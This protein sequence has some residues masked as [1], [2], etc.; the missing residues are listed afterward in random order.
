M[1]RKI[2]FFILIH[3]F[4]ISTTY[5]DSLSYLEFQHIST[6]KG[7]S[8]TT[9]QSIFQDSNG[10]IWIGTQEGLNRYDGQS[11]VQFNNIQDDVKSLS[12]NVIRDIVEDE[13]KIL[14]IATNNGLNRFDSSSNSFSRVPLI[15]GG[16]NNTF[17]LNTLFTDNN[18]VL[19]GTDGHGL[20]SVNTDKSSDSAE[21]V[22]WLEPLKDADVRSIFK[23]SRGRYW[24]GTDGKG[25]WVLDDRGQIISNFLFDENDVSSISHNRIRAIMED[26]KGQ[27]WIGTRGGGLNKFSELDKTFIRYEHD[28]LDLTSL[29]SN[30]VYKILEDSE[31][32]LWIG[33]DGGINI[34][35]PESNDFLRM[36]NRS[37]Q[38]SGLSHNRVLTMIEDKGGLIWL[39][40]LAGLNI[41]NPVTAKFWHYRNISEEKNSLSDNTIHG[42]EESS[43]GDIFV[44]TFGGGLNR[45]DI[46]TKIWSVVDRD[47]KGN[48]L[49]LDKRLTTLMF[50]YKKN[51][52]IGS[53]SSGVTILSP[54]LHSVWRF[55]H[56]VTAPD[57][58]SA[59]GITDIL[60]DSD[61]TTWVATYSGGLNRLNKDGKTFRHY[62]LDDESTNGL[63]SENIFQVIEDDEGYIWLATDGGGVSRLD[64]HTEKIVN[65]VHQK[66]IKNSLSSNAI[67]SIY[68]DSHGRFWIGTQGRGLNRWEPE[69]RRQGKNKFIHY[70]IN[71]GLPGS[72]V[73]GVLE[74]DGGYI[75]ISTN[76]GVSRLDPAT[77]EIKN[78]D[79]ALG[80]HKNEL[81]QGAMLK[82]KDGRLY[83]GGLNG[84]SA[85]YPNEITNNTNIP[86]V[87][88]TDISSENKYLNFDA[89]LTNLKRVNFTHKDY[90]LTFEFAALD[91]AQPDRNQYQYK[92]EGFDPD[93]IQNNNL[94]RATYTN[95][96]SGNYIFKVKGSNNDG[97]WSDE[98]INLHVI[99]E[100]APWVSW[101]AFVIYTIL[102]CVLLILI[103]RSQAK[104]IANQ[105]MFQQQVA[106]KVSSKT[107]IFKK[108]NISLK[109]QVKNHQH[110]SGKDLA[111]GLPNQSFFT[112]QLLISLGWL[113][114]LSNQKNNEQKLCCV[115]VKL[116]GDKDNIEN[117]LIALSQKIA[118]TEENIHL[119]ARWNTNELAMLSFV[120]S[121]KQ[122][123]EQIKK[124][125]IHAESES[126]KNN[127]SIGYTLSP[128]HQ[129]DEQCFKW[130]NILMLTEHAMRSANKQDKNGYIGL[131]ACYQKLSPTLIKNIMTN[132]NILNLDDI[133][134]IDSEL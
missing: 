56:D 33:T 57:S 88:L 62:R 74:D 36:Q 2:I 119:I 32:K 38:P 70:T 26:S 108:D 86:P 60:Q 118:D 73:N 84:I 20:Y 93:W 31:R 29:S 35:R 13:K 5:S 47:K 95:L 22:Q 98:S 48:S 94:N 99:I 51:L 14:W 19:I 112:E 122:A 113:K 39:G 126:N 133:F 12:S 30:R 69:D 116:T 102:F 97:V 96:P 50:D 92:L 104:R 82:A 123:T 63:I 114:N 72:T 37:S 42:L 8:Q 77:N 76:K 132:E 117:Q 52:W 66:E 9:A 54:D 1:C 87:V 58:L 106:D 10:Y 80:I 107:E 40:T 55:K 85:F 71:S 64:K 7:L 130:E 68:Q 79:L 59:N 16:I 6:N 75:W 109:E 125:F 45:L 101:W 18:R 131:R 128:L 24:F 121:N 27:I 46:K 103:I 3:F 134:N 78:Y 127:L 111:T 28:P 89:P 110:N 11:I 17:R 25:L 41:W 21:F 83:F 15:N 115:F 61:N 34:F 43:L 65:F 67:V 90:L 91:Y 81:N 44:A 105:E 23:D 53:V 100:P 49:K 120:E 4:I 129:N 124:L